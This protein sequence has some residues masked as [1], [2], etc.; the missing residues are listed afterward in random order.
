M[1]LLLLLLIR[2][3]E[4]SDSEDDSPAIFLGEISDTRNDQGAWE[5]K[6]AVNGKLINFKLDSGADVSV[7][8]SE[9]YTSEY[10]PLEKAT[11][12]LYGPCR[13]RL[14]CRGKFTATLTYQEKSYEEEIYVIEDL[15]RPLL[16]RHACD[17][18]RVIAKVAEIRSAGDHKQQYVQKHPRLFKGLG[19][20]EGEYT[21][22]TD[23]DVQPFNLTTPRRIPIPQLPCVK[24]EIQRMEELGVID[25]IDEP[26]AW[27][28]PMSS[29]RKATAK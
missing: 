19:C 6:I 11:K 12:R 28:S 8:P 18:L 27:C 1:L 16:S 29:Y 13:Y 7:I 21:I 4:N 26:T 22:T 25:Q 15:E 23:E 10:G 5:T 3:I 20:L 24:K 2:G 9:I 14:K 17:A